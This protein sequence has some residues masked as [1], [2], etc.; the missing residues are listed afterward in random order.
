MSTV[1][2][3]APAATNTPSVPEQM[4]RD[5]RHMASTDSSATASSIGHS[6]L[7]SADY[8][9]KTASASSV[10]SRASASSKK[11]GRA[12][13]DPRLVVTPWYPEGQLK[14]K[15]N[16]QDEIQALYSILQLTPEETA[17]RH[18]AR[19]AIQEIVQ[20]VWPEATVKVYGSFAY[21]MSLPQSSL[22]LVCEDCAELNSEALETVFAQ[23]AEANIAVEGWS[24]GED[25]AFA[26]VNV[27]SVGCMA[28]I[29]FVLS[30]STARRSVSEVRR[31]V[32]QFSAVGECFAVVRLVLQQS[33]CGD[34]RTGGLPSY[35]ALVMIL[36]ACYRCNNPSDP[37][38]LLM[39]FFRLYASAGVG[40]EP[41]FVEDP[42]CAENNLAA[43]CT[44]M[45][46]I[47]SMFKNCAMTL[48][49]THPFPRHIPYTLNTGEVDV[50]QVGGLQGSLASVQVC[51]AFVLF[52]E[53]RTPS[54]VPVTRCVTPALTPIFTASSRTTTCGR[55]AV[56]APPSRSRRSR[57]ASR[58]TSRRAD[59]RKGSTRR[60]KE[61]SGCC[62]NL[63]RLHCFP[64]LLAPCP[65]SLSLSLSRSLNFTSRL[66]STGTS[67]TLCKRE[68]ET[69]FRTIKRA[70][71][72]CRFRC[73]SLQTWHQKKT[74]VIEIPFFCHLAPFRPSMQ[75]SAK[76]K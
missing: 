48:V 75:K 56:R 67:P 63:A 39:H 7:A 32:E 70:H 28:N 71:R 6:S 46:Q 60:W 76:I 65:P 59:R 58:A 72:C 31:L 69:Q 51:C 62:M 38:T 30:K 34:V 11:N 8:G 1:A 5:G 47:R 68:N 17:K 53:M 66:R 20:K 26:C 21:G 54:L 52:R 64:S 50:E 40:N 22:D 13:T 49:C 2:A 43:G 45:P 27:A 25:S 9:S 4:R 33:R 37:S 44:R 18:M 61:K 12:S 42:L 15:L 55:T 16:M 73:W 74:T 29:S 24:A 3:A 23:F 36:H 19:S 57:R 10:S 14:S 35:A 41:L